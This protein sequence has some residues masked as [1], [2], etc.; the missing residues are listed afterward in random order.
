MCPETGFP[1]VSESIVNLYMSICRPVG[2]HV[3]PTSEELIALQKEKAEKLSEEDLDAA[4]G[5]NQV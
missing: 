1:F 2:T 5:W 3:A 4:G